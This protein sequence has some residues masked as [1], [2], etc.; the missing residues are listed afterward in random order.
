VGATPEEMGQR[1]RVGEMTP[2]YCPYYHEC[3]AGTKYEKLKAEVERLNGVVD[4]QKLDIAWLREVYER[5]NKL[6]AKNQELVEEIVR[7]KE[8]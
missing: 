1:E 8:G 4:H 3:Q 7:L 5:Y 2:E 6:E